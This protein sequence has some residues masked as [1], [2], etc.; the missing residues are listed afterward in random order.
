MSDKHTKI[1]CTFVHLDSCLKLLM[2]CHTSAFCTQPCRSHLQNWHRIEPA[3][4]WHYN[5]SPYIHQWASPRAITIMLKDYFST[6][7]SSVLLIS[8]AAKCLLIII[9]SFS[10]YHT[11]FDM[12]SDAACFLNVSRSHSHFTNDTFLLTVTP[13]MLNYMY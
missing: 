8:T 4:W 1:L 3:P 6:R 7:C 9:Q 12:H 5:G 10:P 13:R 2:P 11:L